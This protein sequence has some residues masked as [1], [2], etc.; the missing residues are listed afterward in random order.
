MYNNSKATCISQ[1]DRESAMDSDGCLHKVRSDYR[2]FPSPRRLAGHFLCFWTQSIIGL[3]G[4]YRHLV[5]PDGCIDIVFIN[6]DPPVVVGP[7]TGPFVIPLA[8]G[9]KIVGARLHPG[10][11]PSLLGLPAAELRN[12]SVLLTD[13]WGR[14]SER[15]THIPNEPG[16]PERMSGLAEAL[17]ARL[18]SASPVDEVVVASIRWLARHPR[19]QVAQLSQWTGISSR[20]LNR[21]FLAAVGYGPKMFQSILRFQRVLNLTNRPGPQHLA[22]LA[23]D[24]GYADQA[25][26]TREVR[27]FADCPPTALLRSDRCTLRMSDLFKTLVSAVDDVDGG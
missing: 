9:T 21:R 13:I 26:L 4:E 17:V 23:V 11:A 12:S 25:H 6:D 10:R 5:L 14:A 22:E 3:Q 27:R 7:W 16:L 18:V 19:G 8:A 24:A 1:A 2:E 15:F 20:H